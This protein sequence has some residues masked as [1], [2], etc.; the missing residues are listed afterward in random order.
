MTEPITIS[1]RGT[2]FR[3]LFEFTVQDIMME[4]EIAISQGIEL[5]GKKPP[6]T[7]IIIQKVRGKS[8]N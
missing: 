1:L 3:H 5:R 6:A 2:I 4:K 7:K 8:L